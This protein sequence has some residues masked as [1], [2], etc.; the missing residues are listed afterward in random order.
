[1]LNAQ[2]VTVGERAVAALRATFVNPA[3]A[4]RSSGSPTAIVYDCRVGTSICEMLIRARKTAAASAPLG[5]RGTRTSRAFEGR[6]VKTIVL[7]RPM[8]PASQPA[9]RSETPE[10]T[11]TKKN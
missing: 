2:P 5:I 9:A 10:R 1:T 8:R 11:L 7:I 6:C 4:V 3:A